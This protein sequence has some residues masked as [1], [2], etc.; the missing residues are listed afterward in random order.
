LKGQNPDT[1]TK[2]HSSRVAWDRAWTASTE[3]NAAFGFDRL[4]SLLIPEPNT[5][6]PSV[7]FSGVIDPLGPSS[8]LPIDRVQNRFRYAGEARLARGK[9]IWTFGAEVDRV[10]INGR[11]S[12]SNRGVW[13]F[14]SDFGND[15]LTNFRLG[16]PSRFSFGAG[17][18]DR[19]FRSWEQQY[20]VGDQWR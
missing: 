16:M 4:H 18:L 15:A 10:Q 7:S 8:T 17:N 6:G 12:S 14:R 1:T 5:V 19:G 9:H 2:S 13:T 3:M 20:S 11:E